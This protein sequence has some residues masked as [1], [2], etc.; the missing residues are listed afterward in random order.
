M[1]QDQIKNMMK[2]AAANGDMKTYM[3]LEKLLK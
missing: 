3:K 2:I 1:T